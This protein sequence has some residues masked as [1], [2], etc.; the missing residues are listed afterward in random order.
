MTHAL[1]LSLLLFFL[2]IHKVV[3]HCLVGASHL[4]LISM[5]VIYCWCMNIS[6]QIMERA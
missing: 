3:A 4:T 6:T 5:G 1:P 2:L